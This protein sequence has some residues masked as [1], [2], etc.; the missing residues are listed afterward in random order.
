MNK[1]QEK[2]NEADLY[3]KKKKLPKDIILKLAEIKSKYFLKV[4]N[5]K[6]NLRKKHDYLKKYQ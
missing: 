4:N 3:Q 1:R 5:L 2:Q 6:K